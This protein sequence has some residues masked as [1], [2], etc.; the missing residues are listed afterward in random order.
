MIK[1]LFYKLI[2][3][4]QNNYLLSKTD[5]IIRFLKY[6]YYQNLLIGR[7]FEVYKKLCIFSNSRIK[8]KV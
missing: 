3:N 5:A 6:Y 4:D 7:S 2:M 8:I 1:L